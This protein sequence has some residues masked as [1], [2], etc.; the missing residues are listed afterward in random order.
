MSWQSKTLLV[1]TFPG[2]LCNFCKI[3][4]VLAKGRRQKVVLLGG[5]HHKVAH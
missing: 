1:L 2:R 4:H 5:A 3:R